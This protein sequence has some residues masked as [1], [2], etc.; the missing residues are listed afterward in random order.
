MGLSVIFAEVVDL[1]GRMGVK[2]IDK[3]PACWEVDLGGGWW[4]AV[5][6]HTKPVKCSRGPVVDPVHCYVEFH[7]WPAGLVTPGGGT[8]AAGEL[9]NEDTLIAALRAAKVRATNKEATP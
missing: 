6:G 7:G 9:A 1:A 5:N 2:R 8:I 3:L 4:F